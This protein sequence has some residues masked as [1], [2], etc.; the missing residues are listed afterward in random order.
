MAN[1]LDL[2]INYHKPTY[3]LE[4]FQEIDT[5][6]KKVKLSF[7]SEWANPEIRYTIDGSTPTSSSPLYKEDITIEGFKTINASI[8]KDGKPQALF[9][10]EAGYHLAVGKKVEYLKKWTSYPAGGETA[11][12]NGIV[13]GLTYGD[14]LWQG[15]TSDLDIVIDLEEEITLNSFAANFMQ[16]IGPGVYMPKYVEVSLS[17]DRKTFN[18]VL[19]IENNIPEEHDRLIFKNFKGD[20]KQEK[21]RYIKVFAKN[22][23]GFI[24]TDEVII[25]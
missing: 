21:A 3:E 15:F 7:E 5:L 6:S 10:K 19:K 18:S 8:F 16:L 9:T 14:G 13:G 17:T 1:L 2:T 4:M 22:N 24:F 12:T 20:L 23:K 25:N 11:L